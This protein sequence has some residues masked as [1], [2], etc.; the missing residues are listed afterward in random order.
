MSFGR[1]SGASGTANFKV[2]KGGRYQM[3]VQLCNSDGCTASDAKEILVADTDGSHLVPL[4]AP[5]KENN[6]P[7]VNKSG[8]VVGSYFVEWGCM[9]VSSQSIKSQ[10]RT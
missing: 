4:N 10:H 8:K 5:L 3:Q 2:N 1:P 7:Y 6:R 9:A